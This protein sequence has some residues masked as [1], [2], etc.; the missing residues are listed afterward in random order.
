MQMFEVNEIVKVD[1]A[2]YVKWY[3]ENVP[4][5]EFMMEETLCYVEGSSELTSAI[6]ELTG[7]IGVGSCPNQFLTPTGKKYKAAGY[8]TQPEN[9]DCG[10][11]QTIDGE[12]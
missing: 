9:T 2:G 10:A 7:C 4:S 1:L 8:R 12:G 11:S 3:Q 6:H 5:G